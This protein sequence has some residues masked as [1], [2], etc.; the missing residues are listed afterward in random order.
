MAHADV[1]AVVV[2]VEVKVEAEGKLHEE[3]V[4]EGVEDVV[5]VAAVELLQRRFMMERNP[6]TMLTTTV[7]SVMPTSP[8]PELP[9]HIFHQTF[10]PPV[11]WIFS[12][13]FS[14]MLC[15]RISCSLQ[16]SM[17]CRKL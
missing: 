4:V 13:Y 3:G 5:A 15:W 1:D 7:S 11:S 2:V 10:L 9:V 14:Q 17:L 8:Q 6:G 16:T 12:S